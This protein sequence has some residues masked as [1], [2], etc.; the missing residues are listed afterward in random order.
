MGRDALCIMSHQI[1]FDLIVNVGPFRMM[2]HL[3]CLERY[4]C[5]ETKC[6]NEISKF[7]CFGQF[8]IN[9]VPASKFMQM[10]FNFTIG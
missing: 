3:L 5:H 6:L 4:L 10:F 9:N 8:S 7:K 2:I 1:N